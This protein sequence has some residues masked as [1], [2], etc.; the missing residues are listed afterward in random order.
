MWD[1]MQT[2]VLSRHMPCN[3]HRLKLVSGGPPRFPLRAQRSLNSVS[4]VRTTNAEI[5][6]SLWL[7]TSS[8]SGAASAAHH[9]RYASVAMLAL[10]GFDLR[11]TAEEL[12]CWQYIV[13]PKLTRQQVRY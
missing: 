5:P 3:S 10:C 4:P 7:P 8:G 12:G 2:G 11:T 1:F 6:W 9:L 13:S